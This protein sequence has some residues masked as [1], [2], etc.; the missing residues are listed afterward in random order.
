MSYYINI[1]IRINK[2]TP[3]NKNGQMRQLFMFVYLTKKKIIFP[4]LLKKRSTD[5]LLNIRLVHNPART[6]LY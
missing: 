4:N 5:S 2:Q 3:M 6:L 1:F